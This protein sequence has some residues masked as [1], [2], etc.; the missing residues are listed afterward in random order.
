MEQ[1]MQPDDSFKKELVNSLPQLRRF[2][3]VLTRNREISEDLTQNTVERALQH[4]QQY[5]LGTTMIAWLYTIMKNAHNEDYRKDKSRRQ[6]LEGFKLDLRSDP[7]FAQ[8]AP[9]GIDRLMLKQTGI[10]IEAMPTAQKEALYLVGLEGYSYEEAAAVLKCEVG[11]VKS[12]VSRARERLSQVFDE[13][14]KSGPKKP[15]KPE[16]V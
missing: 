13:E 14:F 3:M 10:I 4:W 6:Q 12:R 16:M 1:K 5:Q 11:T 8:S 9:E 2:A 15:L 7:Y